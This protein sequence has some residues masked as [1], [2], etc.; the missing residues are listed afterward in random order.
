M[1][2]D[3]LSALVGGEVDTVSF[4][5]DYVELRIDYS[6]FRALTDPSGTISG[7]AWQFPTPH[8]ADLMRGYI[9]Q[10]V[11]GIEIQDGQMIR[12]TFESNDVFEVSLRDDDR[13]GPEAAHLLVADEYGETSPERMYVW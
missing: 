12:L 7:Q 3:G 5:R 13:T 10:R 2:H 1:N 8:C 6:I 4:V 9:G 11:S